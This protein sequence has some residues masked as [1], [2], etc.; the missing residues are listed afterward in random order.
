[1]KTT[2]VKLISIALLSTAASAAD[3]YKFDPD[4][5]YAVWHVSHFGFSTVSGKFM[6]EG[7]LVVDKDKPQNSSAN[8]IIH[9]A[10]IDTGVPKLDDMLKGKNFFNTNEFP[11][12][13]F[14]STKVVVTGKDTGKIYG[15]L[16]LRGIAKDVVLD[17]KLNKN[18]MHPFYNKPAL[19]FSGTTKLNRSD[20]EMRGYIPGVSDETSIELQAEAISAN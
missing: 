18:D 15:T 10:N 2:A 4:H 7:T 8:M 12:A 5:T 3:H 14:K 20:F 11:T 17:V 13:T 1:M 6:A 19:G 9:T 16:T